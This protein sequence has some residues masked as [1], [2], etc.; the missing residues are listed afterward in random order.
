MCGAVPPLSHMS[1]RCGAQLSTGEI[2]LTSN[3]ELTITVTMKIIEWR[4]VFWYTKA[5]RHTRKD[6]IK[7]VANE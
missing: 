1:S 3:R 7:M 2:Y 5:T 6:N 4:L